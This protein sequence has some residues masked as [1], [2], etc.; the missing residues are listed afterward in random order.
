MLLTNSFKEFLLGAKECDLSF[1][2][3]VDYRNPL[4][5]H[6]KW[7]YY[8][9]P[10]AYIDSLIWLLE[11][12][13]KLDRFMDCIELFLSEK[14]SAGSTKSVSYRPTWKVDSLVNWGGRGIILYVYLISLL[15]WEFVGLKIL[16]LI[17]VAGTGERL[18]S[19]L[20]ARRLYCPPLCLSEER[21][22]S[23]A[24]Q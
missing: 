24:P 7:W 17:E 14:A 21:S 22:Y 18:T 12:W 15:T 1:E 19:L 13:L 16:S 4:S 23:S 8:L 11:Y 9:H 5:I 2:R 6:N 3:I 10:T 20:R